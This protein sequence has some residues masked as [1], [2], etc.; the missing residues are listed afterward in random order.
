MA[1]RIEYGAPFEGKQT[2]KS[3]WGRAAGMA[4][5]CFALFLLLTELFWPEG[6]AALRE[7]LIPGDNAVT[8]G[9]FDELVRNVRAGEAFSDAAAEFCREILYGG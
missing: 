3:G 5:V 8:A 4:L 2:I 9:A 7:A 6:R 1:Y